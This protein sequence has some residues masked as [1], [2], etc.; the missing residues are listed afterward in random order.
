MQQI[1]ARE[2][3]AREVA[4]NTSR[5]SDHGSGRDT[6][7]RVIVRVRSRSAE[8]GRYGARVA[9]RRPQHPERVAVV[10]VVILLVINLAI[11]GTLREVR[12]N[13]SQNLP[14][15][16]VAVDPQQGE[17]ILPQASISISLLARYTG[18]L[19]IDQHLIPQD[20]LDNPSIYEF[21]FQPKVGHDITAFRPGAHTATFEAWPSNKTY[22]QAKTGRLITPY[23]WN[24]KVG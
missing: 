8:L 5:H 7:V 6:R 21:V 22:E 19:S 20:Q 16:I 2:H 14:G 12:G 4:A 17:N 9:L 11:F 10:A 3:P 15:P 23:S 13:P 1:A 24:F 18:Q